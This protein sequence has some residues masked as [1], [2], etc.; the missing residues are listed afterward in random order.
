MWPLQKA[1]SV[2]HV[3]KK[4]KFRVAVI[5]SYMVQQHCIRIVARTDDKGNGGVCYNL[6][7]CPRVL[8]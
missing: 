7:L 2:K 8:E 3:A 6:F 4:Q 1:G 5:D